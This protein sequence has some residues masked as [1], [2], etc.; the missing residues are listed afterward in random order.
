MTLQERK[1]LGYERSDG[2]VGVRNLVAVIYTVDCA[3]LV[4]E[5]IASS[6]P[7]GI[8]AGW[9]SCFS[10]EDTHDINTLI[11]IAKNPNVGSTIV[12]G[13]G[14]QHISPSDV[15]REIR[16]TGKE[17]EILTIQGVGGTRKTIEKGVK[18]ATKMSNN[19]RE[20]KRTLA[21]LSKLAIGIKLDGQGQSSKISYDLLREVGNGLSEQGGRVLLSSRM[22]YHG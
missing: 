11:G 17:A 18:I 4:S 7:N 6:I 9:Y 10:T 19:L 1:F 2:S 14:C 8:A 3:R 13:L 20:L 16:K 22:N 12:I 15:A 5:T 21:P